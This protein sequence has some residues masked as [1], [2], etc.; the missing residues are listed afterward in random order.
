MY[1]PADIDN[2]VRY[3]GDQGIEHVEWYSN[4]KAANSG[5]NVI[6]EAEN[7]AYQSGETDPKE[8][9]RKAENILSNEVEEV[10]SQAKR[11]SIYASEVILAGEALKSDETIGEDIAVGAAHYLIG[12]YTAIAYEH[13][14]TIFPVRQSLKYPQT[15]SDESFH[16]A[17]NQSAV[18]Q[19]KPQAKSARNKRFWKKSKKTSI[20]ETDKQSPEK[21]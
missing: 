6:R 21:Q 17:P 14:N 2:I 8:L 20:P 10:E 9:I 5:A 18:P 1:S 3:Y 7:I 13:G 15:V 19:L 11:I 16:P 4:I 12:E